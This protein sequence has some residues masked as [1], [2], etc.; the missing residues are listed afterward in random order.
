MCTPTHCGRPWAGGSAAFVGLPAFIVRA[1]ARVDP[2]GLHWFEEL[3]DVDEQLARGGPVGTADALTTGS[4]WLMRELEMASLNVAGVV[5][6]VQL[7][8]V[9]PRLS[10]SK[11]DS[12]A[13]GKGRTHGCSCRDEAPVKYCPYHTVTRQ[14]ERL[15]LMFS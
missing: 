4:W 8:R 15:L 14:K 10:C 11:I 6:N 5:I 9:E 2:P 12:K 1:C 3:P 13:I 7:L